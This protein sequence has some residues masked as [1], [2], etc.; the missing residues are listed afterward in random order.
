MKLT[1]CM[2]MRKMHA[3]TSLSQNTCHPSGG[4]NL[5]TKQEGRGRKLG[6]NDWSLL[7]ADRAVTVQKP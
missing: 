3:Q 4:R 1:N 5:A 6:G 2:N 7:A